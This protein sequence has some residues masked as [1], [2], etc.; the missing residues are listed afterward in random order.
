MKLE[1]RRP[2][3]INSA[4]KAQISPR[5]FAARQ[6]VSEDVARRIISISKDGDQARSIAEL[7]K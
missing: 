1:L 5:L 6:Q 2:R 4:P 3:A 7:M